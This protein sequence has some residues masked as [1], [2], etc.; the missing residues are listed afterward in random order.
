M[1]YIM[2][3]LP[4]FFMYVFPVFFLWNVEVYTKPVVA[5]VFLG[6]GFILWTVQHL[7]IIGLIRHPYKLKK[8]HQKVQK[9]GKP[10]QATILSS[11]IVGQ[12]GNLPVYNLVLTFK[13][14]AGSPVKAILKTS[15]TKPHEKRFETGKHLDLKLNQNGLEPPFTVTIGKYE[16]SKRVLLWLWLFFDI[17]YSIALFIVLYHFQ[18]NGLG[19]R[20]LGLHS[21][22]VWAPI[23][24][25]S[26]LVFMTK[27]YG[28]KSDETQ[29]AAYT[30][31]STSKS[32]DLAQLLLHGRA[33]YGEI[34]SYNQTG[35]Y[36]N[37]QPMIRFTIQYENENGDLVHGYHN[38]IVMLTE[39]HTLR[40]SKIDVLYLPGKPNVFM[41]EYA[42]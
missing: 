7:L 30:F 23:V 32:T 12:D 2:F 9:T 38:Q 25:I 11:E 40:K 24:G 4:L 29:E 20:F 31:H 37:E 14:L 17:A 8:K 6:L 1:Q 3:G 16:V 33:S 10:V 39:L 26:S 21:P 22:W 18:N 36:I 5:T 28:L 41:Y 42:V 19:W 27:I 13:N 35:T 15:D 34:Q